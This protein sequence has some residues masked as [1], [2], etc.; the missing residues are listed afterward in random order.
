[1][2]TSFLARAESGVRLLGR[3]NGARRVEDR[4]HNRWRQHFGQQFGLTER[5][6]VDVQ[7]YT[8][9][10]E[11]C[12]CLRDCRVLYSPIRF[13]ADDIQFAKSRHHILVRQRDAFIDLAR[14]TPGRSEVDE[15]GAALAAKL[16]DFLFRER[17]P[18]IYRAQIT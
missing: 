18:R 2:I 11:L 3:Q 12:K 9:P 8:V 5:R 7:R 16:T 1:M 10:A 13:H 15:H 14:D 4:Q 6:V 17:H